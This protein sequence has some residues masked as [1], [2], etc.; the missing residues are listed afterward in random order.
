MERCMELRIHINKIK[1]SFLTKAFLFHGVPHKQ[2]VND[3][4]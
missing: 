1:I 2:D 4:K 3:K